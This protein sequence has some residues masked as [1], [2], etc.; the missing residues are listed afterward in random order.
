[1]LGLN[2]SKERNERKVKTFEGGR[3]EALLLH[4]FKGVVT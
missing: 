3:R 1:V 2:L 4:A